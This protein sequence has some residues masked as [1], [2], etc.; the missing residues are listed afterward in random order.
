MSFLKKLTLIAAVCGAG[1]VQAT[2]MITNG[3]FDGNANGWTLGGGCAA[4]AYQTGGN[5][6]GFILL[7]SCGEADS[8]PSASQTVSGL[9]VGHTYTVS[10]DERLFDIFSGSGAGK[11]FGVFLG[12]DG[13]NALFT[14]EYLSTDWKNFSTSFVATSATQMLTFA[15]ELDQRTTGVTVRS[16]VS[17][18]LDNVQLKDAN[19]PEPA[20]LA[21]L[22]LGMAGIAF[23]RRK[24]A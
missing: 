9:T 18:G 22:G 14:N 23:M 24:Q 16:D 2:P 4:A 21:L 11:T 12:A 8:D 17:Y 13:G 1:A 19:V 10:W 3:G 6:T 5:G 15:G 20:S 7:N